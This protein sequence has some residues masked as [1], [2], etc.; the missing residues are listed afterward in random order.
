[1]I[2]SRRALF[3]APRALSIAFIAFISLFALGVFSEGH[4]FWRTLQALVVQTPSRPVPPAIR[5]LWIVT[6]A[7]P[8]FS[9]ATLFRANWRKRGSLRPRS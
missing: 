7:G 6:L 9:I 4:G 5:V 2:L 8:A 1:V 3:C